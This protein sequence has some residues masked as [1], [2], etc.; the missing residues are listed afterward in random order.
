MGQR[1]PEDNFFAELLG[2]M[3]RTVFQVAE[4][5]VDAHF[6]YLQDVILLCNSYGLHRDEAPLVLSDSD[7]CKSAGGEDFARNIN[8]LRYRH[9]FWQSFM[10]RSESP[11]HDEESLFLG[12]FEFVLRD[13]LREPSEAVG[14]ERIGITTYAVQ[15]LDT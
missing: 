7:I 5:L 6:S 8:P 14:R 3:V 15:N 10:D 1:I 13:A 12:G 4:N 11:Q 9:R 2:R